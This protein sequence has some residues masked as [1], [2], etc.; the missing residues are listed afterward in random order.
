M[1]EKEKQAWEAILGAADQLPPEKAAF[2]QGY[3]QGMADSNGQMSAD[4][5]PA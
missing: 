5:Q 1:S 3:A 4:A 2:L